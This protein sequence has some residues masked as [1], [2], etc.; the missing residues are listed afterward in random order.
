MAYEMK[1]GE[2]SVFRNEK[3][4]EDWHPEFRG[5]VMLPDGV[6]HWVDV[7]ERVG[8]DGGSMWLSIR[9][10]KAVVSRHEVEKSNGYQR[11]GGDEDIPF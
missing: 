6:V 9:I 7:R 3:K 1:P 11:S 8:K 2:G 4:V 5:R 10:G